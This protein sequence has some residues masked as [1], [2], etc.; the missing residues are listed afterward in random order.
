MSALKIT[1][2]VCLGALGMMAIALPSSA[3]EITICNKGEETKLV[4]LV[5]S[6]GVGLLFDNWTAIGRYKIEGGACD[7]Y[8]EGGRD[9]VKAYI[10]VLVPAPN[11]TLRDASYNG[12]YDRRNSVVFDY[13][14]WQ[15]CM[16]AGG[17]FEIHGSQ[18]QL[19][20]CGPGTEKRHFSILVWADT[21][22]S[23]SLDLN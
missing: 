3:G 16:N 17:P 6:S 21:N 14:D 5:Y 11:G 2:G 10:N 23:A 8:F 4:S 22:G 7:T 9:V 18:R 15:F 13:G 19:E 12:A 20:I 1:A